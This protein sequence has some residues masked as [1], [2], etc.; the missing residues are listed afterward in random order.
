VA[1]PGL[2]SLTPVLVG[3]RAIGSKRTKGDPS[4]LGAVRSDDGAMCAALARTA[5]VLLILLD[6]EMISH[7]RN[8]VAHHT[9]Q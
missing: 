3:G 6:D 4:A 7:T 2:R 1:K 9:R 5:A 8:V